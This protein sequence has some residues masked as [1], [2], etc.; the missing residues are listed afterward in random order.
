MLSQQG[1]SNALKL[2][3]LIID[4]P[5]SHC[6]VSFN[7]PHSMHYLSHFQALK[8]LHTTPKLVTHMIL[9]ATYLP[10][11]S[12]W[13]KRTSHS[14]PQKSHHTNHCLLTHLA[15]TLSSAPFKNHSTALQHHMMAFGTLHYSNLV[16]MLPYSWLEAISS[17]QW[18][19]ASLNVEVFMAVTLRPILAILE[20]Y[21]FKN[22]SHS[23]C[24]WLFWAHTISNCNRIVGHITIR[25]GSFGNW[26]VRQRLES[27]DTART[28]RVYIIK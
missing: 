24:D 7:I 26:A 4:D 1:S 22:I 6:R 28:M 15:T 23:H 3:I 19:D 10:L 5:L 14:C 11:H 17:L 20:A 2:S 8:A 21:S 12:H 9:P 16:Q 25:H 18:C 13:W 27:F